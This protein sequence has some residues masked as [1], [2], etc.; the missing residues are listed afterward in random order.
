LNR[1][2]KSDAL[3]PTRR[4]SYQVPVSFRLLRERETD[5][6]RSLSGLRPALGGHVILGAEAP[7]M[8]ADVL[9]N[10]EERRIAV[11]PAA[12]DRV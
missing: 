8:F 4:E 7:T 9:R 6:A 11:V 1:T 3:S 5:G 10:L 2:V 12:W